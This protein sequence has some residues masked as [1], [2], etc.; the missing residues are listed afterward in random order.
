MCP[1]CGAVLKD[2][3]GPTHP[4]MLSSPTCF[5]AYTELLAFE[6][7]D[8]ALMPTHRLSVDAFAVQHPGD[9]V[10]RQAIQSVGLHLARLAVQL[11]HLHVPNRSADIM[12]LLGKYKGELEALS[13]PIEFSMTIADV[14]A[15]AGTPAHICAVTNWAKSA[16]NDWREHH[17]YILDWAERHLSIDNR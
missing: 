3:D 14:Q 17:D 8:P 10:S 15:D 13:P 11:Q 6:Y 7:S 5:A 1:G 2:I 4:Y 9:G 16:W 12:L